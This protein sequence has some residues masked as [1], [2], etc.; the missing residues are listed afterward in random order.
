LSLA[1]QRA[2]GS[3]R[4]ADVIQTSLAG[5]PYI[6]QL[7]EATT[8]RELLWELPHEVRGTLLRHIIARPGVVF[9]DFVFPHGHL[10]AATKVSLVMRWSLRCAIYRLFCVEQIGGVVESTYAGWIVFRGH[11]QS[12]CAKVIE[13]ISKTRESRPGTCVH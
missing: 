9:Q 13:L 2:P 7:Q 10:T 12:S 6:T 3:R 5:L 1:N 11:G 4:T 8:P